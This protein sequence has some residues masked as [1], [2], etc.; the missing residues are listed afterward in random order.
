MARKKLLDIGC[1]MLDAGQQEN[2]SNNPE[3]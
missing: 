1:W 2:E 3:R